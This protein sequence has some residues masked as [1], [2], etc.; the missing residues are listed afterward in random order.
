VRTF[1]FVIER[2]TVERGEIEIRAESLES[3]AR[4]AEAIPHERGT[5]Q[6]GRVSYAKAFD[7][8]PR[9][10]VTFEVISARPIG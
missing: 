2:T 6:A 8:D 5:W 7:E 4:I 3:A 10:G 1:R 9:R